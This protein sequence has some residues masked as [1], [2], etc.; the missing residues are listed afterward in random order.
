MT[1]GV[2]SPQFHVVFDDK[3]SRVKCLHDNKIPSQWP[4][5]FNTASSFYVDED[6]A[7][8]S[9]YQPSFFNDP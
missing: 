3:F 5:L 7:K 6:F 8:T 4:E 1:T 9:F 2:V